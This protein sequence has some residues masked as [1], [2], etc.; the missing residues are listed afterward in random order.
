VVAS[1]SVSRS[2]ED[3]DAQDQ[4]EDGAENN[5]SKYVSSGGDGSGGDDNS[6]PPDMD[7][8]SRHVGLVAL[9]IEEEEQYLGD[10]HM[11]DLVKVVAPRA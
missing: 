8:N 4:D 9:T 10:L 6:E 2:G 7:T 5:K 11:R 3:E 1:T